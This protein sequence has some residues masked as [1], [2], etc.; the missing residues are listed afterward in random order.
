MRNPNFKLGWV[1]KPNIAGLTH[2]HSEITQEDILAVYQ[3]TNALL[4]GIRSEL[5]IIIDNRMVPMESLLSLADLQQSFH[6]LKN[7]FLRYIVMVKPMHLKISTEAIPIEK[8]EGVQLKYVSSI[9]E[10]M[11]FLMEKNPDLKKG[12][13][14]RDFFQL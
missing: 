8:S 6:F 2:F 5:D 10:A 14:D 3:E 7:E 9:Q 12:I 11:N 1:M 13:S 4:Q